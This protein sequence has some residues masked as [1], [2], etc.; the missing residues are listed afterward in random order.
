MYKKLTYAMVISLLAVVCA[1]TQ[2][3]TFKD[4]F[5]GVRDYLKDGVSARA[6]TAF[7]GKGGANETSTFSRRR[8][9]A[10]VRCSYSLQA[11]T[12]QRYTY[13]SVPVQ[14]GRR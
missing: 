11:P 12:G 6:G 2:G 14:A 1:T 8:L 5:D 13:G 10:P 9:T 4:N 3:A 7:I